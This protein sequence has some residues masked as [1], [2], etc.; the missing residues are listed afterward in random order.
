VKK[1]YAG[2]WVGEFG[3]EVASWNPS[4][5]HIAQVYDHVTVETQPGSEYLYEFA[6]EIVLNPRQPDYDMYSGTPTKPVFQPGPDVDTITP[7]HFWHKH[8]RTEFRAIKIAGKSDGIHPKAWRRLGSEKP[9]HVAD[10]MCAF[11]G[12]KHYKGRSF[13]EKEYEQQKCEGLV[14]L[15]LEAGYSVACYGNTDNRYVE[16]TIDFRGQP[17]DWL[18]SALAAA[19][20]AVGPSSGTIHLAS[21]CCVPHVTWYGRPV[22]SMERYLSYW[23]PFNTAVTFIDVPQPAPEL[24]FKSCVARM[25]PSTPLKNWTKK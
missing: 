6:D 23:N 10:I 1:L 2:P 24:A 17:L 5:R 13:P 7:M 8:A 9:E 25:D 11:R 18:C 22:V 19:K 20:V 14:S 12:S 16:G 3:W 4:L 21:A 15:L